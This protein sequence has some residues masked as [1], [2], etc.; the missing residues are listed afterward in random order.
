M[1]IKGLTTTEAKTL[2]HRIGPNKIADGHRF[3]FFG[4]L[5]R[6]T[7]NILNILLVFAALISLGIGD[8][9]DGVLIFTIVILN[10]S[11]SFWQ[12]YKAE[13]TLEE[14]KNL[15]FT[16]V[17][18]LRDGHTTSI[19]GEELVPGDV[20]Y[21][22]IG[23]KIT[24]D[25]YVL[26]ARNFEVNE[27][28]LTGEASPVYK[29]EADAEKSFVF[30]GTLVAGGRATV[31]VTA[32]GRNTRFGKI[33]ETLQSIKETETPLQKQ[34]KHLALNTAIGALVFSTLIFFIGTALGQDRITMFL[35]AVSSAVA[36]IPEGLPTIILVTLAVG[37]KRMALR[38]AV[39]R[40]I[41]A[42]E[43]LGSINV[44]C[45]D[46][47][48]TLTRGE[49][50]ASKIWFNH[51]LYT[52]HEFKHALNHPTGKRFID[53][54]LI[55]NTASLA[56]K[57][58]HGTRVVLGDSTEGALLML[59]RELGFDYEVHKNQVRIL[60]EYSFDQ[61]K[62]TMS[63]VVEQNGKV[64]SL[65]KGSPEYLVVNSTRIF[66]DNKLRLLMEEDKDKLV[67]SY[68]S[69]TKDGLRVLGFAYK[70]IETAETYDRSDTERDLIFLGF[71]A[72]SDPI[73]DEVKDSIRLAG[74][75][76]IR[77]IMVTGDNE[78]TAM[79]VARQLNMVE[80]GDEVLTGKD[81]AKLDDSQ[82]KSIL[83]K[84]KVFAR[85]SPE[86]KLRIV[87]GLQELSLTVAVTGDGINDALAL[88][89]AEIGI[90]MGKKGTDVAKETADIVI[91][92]DN[93]ASIVQAIEEGRTI[94][95]NV[96]KSI[97][98]LFSTNVSELLTI[99]IALILGLPSPL[100]PAQILWIN[101][102]SDGL[103]AIALALDPKDPM[104]MKKM[105][106][107]KEHQLLDLN[108]S[109][110]LMVIGFVVSVIALIVYWHTYKS[111][112]NVVLAR[113]WTFSILILCQLAVAFI[114][115]GNFK[116][117]NRN[118]I[119]ACLIT[120]AVQ[121]L[122]LFDPLFHPVFKIQKPW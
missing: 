36:A 89:Q 75:A 92:D 61:T 43:A 29:R 2:L 48:G 106:R 20:T 108:S 70:D 80:E 66:Q 93:Y 97:R 87:K 73:R 102:V 35:T 85:T 64:A 16:Y 121:A 54:L 96:L 86:D 115:R 103:P 30:A 117:Y 67:K 53:T 3:S 31:R 38:K 98:Y 109:L 110:I 79:A 99:L 105:P 107:S 100:L 69:L 45:T 55:P 47:T 22:E 7:F 34:I 118:L 32:T 14:L 27:S 10:T 101:L 33:A 6:E 40:K 113:T 76:G 12:E 77:T 60:E 116:A 1:E 91:T 122:I 83:L 62:K 4:L 9:I 52:P 24:T 37:V 71:V 120:V 56:Y 84:V 28:S 94:Y 41:I 23:D 65:V 51:K 58:D 112:G 17:K 72:L 13:R 111:S 114:I 95:D 49:M 119:I 104:A 44:I 15:T 78:L 8:T 50:K 11:I 19:N 81:L 39:V 59:G 18:V 57:F 63:M 82:F 46:K 25:A 26:E 42:V 5:F 90:A 68:E 88:K 21:L 74:Q